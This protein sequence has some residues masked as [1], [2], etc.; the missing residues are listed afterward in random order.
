[1]YATKKGRL[2][3]KEVAFGVGQVL[4]SHLNTKG[5]FVYDLGFEVSLWEGKLAFKGLRELAGQRALDVCIAAVV[6]DVV[7]VVVVVFRVTPFYF[8]LIV[9]NLSINS[10]NRTCSALASRKV[11]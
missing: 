4:P 10:T 5:V 1:V 2:H 11:V 9:S 3:F 7:V 8:L 6:V